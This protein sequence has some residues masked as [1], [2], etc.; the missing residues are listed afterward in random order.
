MIFLK[1][2]EYTL[3]AKG[4]RGKTFFVL[5]DMHIAKKRDIERIA[6]AKSYIETRY[7]AHKCDA[8]FLVGDL[9]DSM[10]IF[11]NTTLMKSL[12]EFIKFLGSLAPTFI[13]IGNHDI[14]RY[15]NAKKDNLIPQQ[16]LLY[17]NKYFFEKIKAYK[18]VYFE[19]KII[20]DI[21]DGYTV[22]I[23]NPTLDYKLHY[24]KDDYKKDTAFLRNL[25]PS[26]TNILLCHFPNV[27]KNLH[28]E[29]LLHDVDLAVTGH[30]HNG[31]TQFLFLEKV[32]KLLKMPNRGLITPEKS[33]KFKDTAQMR[34]LIPLNKR[35]RLFINP[36]FTS[37]A[38]NTK[39]LNFFDRFFYTGSTEIKFK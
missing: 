20:Y 25:N 1:T 23:Y 10:D 27:I 39:I 38:P 24:N 17:I 19:D 12:T 4:P 9:V 14:Y 3:D 13:A 30:N 35:T 22:S 33:L 5:S 21:E 28:E 34:G 18:N 36:A 6:K 26:K 2:L 37:L 11:E 7:L 16:S 31:M 29:K 15:E 8:F 32:L